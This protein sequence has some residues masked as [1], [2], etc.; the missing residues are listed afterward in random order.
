[1]S[2]VAPRARQIA[3]QLLPQDRRTV[4][5]TVKAVEAA[6]ET[7]RGLRAV[8][9]HD[10]IAMHEAGETLLRLLEAARAYQPD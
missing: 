8:D 6:L 4:P 10:E 2:N 7:L 9:A 5:P 3:G 1:M